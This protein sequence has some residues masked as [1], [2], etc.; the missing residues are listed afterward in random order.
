MKGRGRG[1]GIEGARRSRAPFLGGDA[2][3]LRS[4]A[5]PSPPLL[6]HAAA[7]KRSPTPSKRCPGDGAFRLAGWLAPVPRRDKGL[8]LRTDVYEVALAQ[9]EGALL[10]GGAA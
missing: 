3:N 2:E 7:C 9:L 5:C 10:G 4:A 1:R 6:P 8:A